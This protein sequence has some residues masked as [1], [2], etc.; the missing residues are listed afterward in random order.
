[1]YSESHLS[2]R[3][4]TLDYDYIGN[5]TSGYSGADIYNVCKE[6]AMIPMRRLMQQLMTV[7]EDNEENAAAVDGDINIEPVVMQDVTAA[8]SCTSTHHLLIVL[9]AFLCACR[10]KQVCNSSA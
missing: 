3:S 1:M 9:L 5:R 2:S 8:L 6:A 10:M 4:N 7:T